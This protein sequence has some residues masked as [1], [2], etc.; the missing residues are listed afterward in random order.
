MIEDCCDALGSK[1]NG[2]HV[3]KFGDIEPLS[4]YLHTILQW[5][6]V[7]QFLLTPQKL[8][9]SMESIRDWGRDCYAK[10]DA[11]MHKKRFDWKFEINIWL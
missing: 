11:I 1:Y 2:Q 10:Q 3:G 8:K 9:K 5:V 6:K 7:V 4:F